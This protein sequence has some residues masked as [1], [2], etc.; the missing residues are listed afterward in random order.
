[1]SKILKQ[2]TP[3]AI[4]EQIDQVHIAVENKPYL[5]RYVNKKHGELTLLDH[6]RYL[7]QLQHIYAAF[8]ARIN[9]PDFQPAFP[10]D[11]KFLVNRA[12]QIQADLDFLKVYVTDQDK[13]F[14]RTS[15]STYKTKLESVPFTP[16]GNLQFLAH[17]L[18]SVL[19]DLNGG[20]LVLKSK[21]KTL[22]AK[23][24]IPTTAETGV[25][26]YTF[27]VD[28]LMNFD[29][30]LSSNIPYANEAE[31]NSALVPEKYSA[32]G[33]AVLDAFEQQTRIVE[34][35]EHSRAQTSVAPASALPKPQTNYSPGFFSCNNIGKAA[36]YLAAGVAFAATIYK[37]SP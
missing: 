35:L 1:M 6:Y 28:A 19:G 31:L 12:E 30:W 7:V 15:T 10:Q 14:I 18:V 23:H 8:A 3:V 20:A 9:R 37:L 29:L 17:F 27:P 22:Y 24:H 21:V 25:A 16:I 11:L 33:K 2:I 5:Q 4:H 36:A 26:F 13:D 34:M 32:I